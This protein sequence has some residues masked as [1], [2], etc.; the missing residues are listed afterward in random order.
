M[1]EPVH[2]D[3]I[4]KGIKEVA[5]GHPD[6]LAGSV[7]MTEA[8]EK[9]D[10]YDAAGFAAGVCYVK[11]LAGMLFR[12]FSLQEEPNAQEL[13]TNLGKAIGWSCAVAETKYEI[14]QSLTDV[15]AEFEAW[16]DEEE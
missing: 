16:S 2:I 11:D 8:L 4:M 13:F 1:S 9:F 15:L 3:D 5:E 12:T 10:G 6:E 7:A 14:D